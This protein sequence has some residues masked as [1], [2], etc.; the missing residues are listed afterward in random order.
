LYIIFK[1]HF[2]TDNAS[3]NSTVHISDFLNLIN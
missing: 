3:D 2:R 1:S